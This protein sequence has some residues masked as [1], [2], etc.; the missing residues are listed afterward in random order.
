MS[1]LLW[2]ILS[3]LIVSVVSLV[4]AVFLFFKEETIKKIIT[5]LVA[6]SAGAL[7]AGAL[8]HL[9]PET[10]EELGDGQGVFLLVIAGFTFFFLLEQFIHWHHCHRLPSEHKHPVTYLILIADSIHNFL[11]GLAVGS[12]FMVDVRL[13]VITALV[14][15]MHEI[16][17][18]LGDF[19]ILLHGGW[20]KSQA[21]LFN[22]FSAL[23]MV[24]GGLLAYLVSARTEVAY[25]LPLAAGSFIYIAA[26]DL[27]P[28]VKHNKNIGRNLLHFLTFI[29]GILLIWAVGQLE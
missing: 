12:A 17:Q 22:L 19:G 15:T 8:L 27:I 5:P 6:F 20:K 1:I 25:L 18:E 10:V 21:L 16:P 4:G 26:A 2:I 9:I 14:V 24:F 13:G 11:D 28:E 23:T 29:V 3:T 7:L